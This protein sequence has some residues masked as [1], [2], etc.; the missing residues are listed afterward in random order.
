MLKY[1]L[2]TNIVIYTIKNRPAHVRDS[3]KLHDGQMCISSVTFGELVYGAE[4]SSQPERNLADIQGLVARL[5]IV[6]FDEHATEH[7]GQL[8][9]ELYNIGQPIGPYD[10][11][12]AGHARSMGLILVTNNEKEFARVPGLRLQN[13][14]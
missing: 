6:P 13:W 8:R 14:I 2:D 5:E 1:M 10:M 9:A 11:M 3:F 7:F 4:R 12:I